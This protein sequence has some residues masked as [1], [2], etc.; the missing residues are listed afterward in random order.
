MIRT[1]SRAYEKMRRLETCLALC[2]KFCMVDLIVAMC[3][4]T[5]TTRVF[6][7]WKCEREQQLR[8]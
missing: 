5:V 7:E 6:G 8:V 1:Q 3:H 2:E 4:A